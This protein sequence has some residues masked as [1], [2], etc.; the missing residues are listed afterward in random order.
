MGVTTAP[1]FTTLPFRSAWSQAMESKSEVNVG[2][3]V[4]RHLSQLKILTRLLDHELE[5]AKGAR[6]LT[7]DRDL[8]ENVIDTLEIFTDDCEGVSGG[9]RERASKGEQKPVVARL[10]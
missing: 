5:A 9:A 6:E 10:N 7:L 1:P 3:F 2:K 4:G 8:I